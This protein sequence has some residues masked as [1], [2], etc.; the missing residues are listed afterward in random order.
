MGDQAGLKVERAQAKKRFTSNLRKLNSSLQ[1]GADIDKIKKEALDLEECFGKLCDLHSDYEEIT[2]ADDN[3]YLKPIT[4]GFNAGMKSYYSALKQEKEIKAR[5]EGAPLIASVER[6]F[7]DIEAGIEMLNGVD[8][9]NFDVHEVMVDKEGLE[10]R[11]QEMFENIKKASNTVDTKE[12]DDKAG[13]LAVKASTVLRSSEILIRKVKDNSLKQ[14]SSKKSEGINVDIE[15]PAVAG[16]KVIENSNEIIEVSN[17]EAQITE[18]SD[19]VD[20]NSDEITEVSS[21]QAQIVM[22]DKRLQEES[23][24]KLDY[25]LHQTEDDKLD[26][27]Q[28]STKPGKNIETT[29][30]IKHEHQKQIRLSTQQTDEAIHQLKRIDLP[31]FHGDRKQWPEFKA[32]FKH[33]AESSMRSQQALAYELKRHV[34]A[35]ADVLIQSVYS[36][37]PGAYEKMWRKLGEVYDDPGA[38]V[39]AALSSLHNLRRPS[40]DFKSLVGFIN[41]IEAVHA[42]L[43]EL[44][45]IQCVSVRDVDTINNLLP[46]AVKMEWNRSYNELGAVEKL[47]PFSKYM[48]FLEKERA[49]MI[50][51]SEHSPLQ[52]TRRTTMIGTTEQAFQCYVHKAM[53]H[54][55]LNCRMFRRMTTQEK[56]DFCRKEKL[57]FRCLTQHKRDECT[58]GPCSKCGKSHNPIMCPRNPVSE[59]NEAAPAVHDS[60]PEEVNARGYA[61]ASRAAPLAILPIAKVNVKADTKSPALALL[62]SGSDASYVT[63]QFA[64]KAGLKPLRK[65]K[66]SVTTMGNVATSIPTSL[67]KVPLVST[68]GEVTH[69]EAFGIK[70][71][72]G[73]VSR[74]DEQ[75]VSRLFPCHDPKALQRHKAEV[76]ILIGCDNF[77][78]HPKRELAKAGKNLSL[79]AG[80]L[81]LCLQG[82]HES[83]T[84]KTQLSS[85][86]V[87]TIHEEHIVETRAHLLQRSVCLKSKTDQF[88][89]GEELGTAITPKCGSCRCGKC[90][91]PGH[92]YS[93]VEQQELQMIRDGL[94][95][96]EENERWIAA[97]P[98]LRAPTALPNNYTAT[99]AKLSR[100]EKRLAKDPAWAESYKTQLDDMVDRGVAKKLSAEDIENWSGPTFYISHLAVTSP[101]SASTPIRIVFNSSESHNGISLNSCLAKGPD[102]Y[103]NNILGLLLRWRENLVAMVADIRKM[104]HSIYLEELETHCHRYLWR[105]LDVTKEPDVY[106]IQRVNMGDKPASAIAT[107]ALRMTA[108]LQEK[109]YPQAAELITNSSY[110]DDLIDSVGTSEKAVELAKQVDQVLKFGG[111]VIKCWQFSFETSAHDST[112][113]Q[114][115][116]S[117]LKAASER[118]TAVLGV[119]WIPENDSIVF[120]TTVN[121]SQKSH[122]IHNMPNIKKENLVKSMPNDLS[123][124]MVLQQVMA[125][126]DPLGI[127]SPFL[128]KAKILLRETWELKLGWDDPLPDRIRNSWIQFF[129]K[130]YDVDGMVFERA[131]TPQ[132]TIGS[133]WLIIFSDGSNLAYGFAAYIRWK[134]KNGK[135]WCRLIMAKSRIAP[136]HKT[137]TPRMELNGALLSKRARQVIETEMRFN[138]EKVIHLIDSLTVHSMLHKTS[139]RFQI[140]EGSRIGEIQAATQGDMSE[141]AWLPG[142][143]NIADHVTRGLDPED[144]SQDTEWWKGPPMLYTDFEEWDI[145]FS[146]DQKAESEKEMQCMNACVKGQSENIIQF[147]KFGKMRKLRLVIA[148]IFGIAKH[149]SFK[150]GSDSYLE[151]K[152]IDAANDYLIKVAQ[153]ELHLP[154]KG[155]VANKYRSLNP[156]NDKGIIVVGTRMSRHNPMSPEGQLQALL[157]TKHTITKMLMREAHEKG[158]LGRDA[159]LAKF[160]EHFWTPHADKLAKAVKMNCQLC[161]LREAKLMKQCMGQL[162]K[163]R[164]TPG[165]PFAATML[166]LLGPFYTRGEVQKR[167]TG[168]CYF[169]LLT[170]L[171]ARAIHLECIFGYDTSHFLLGLSRFV[172]LRGWP[173]VIYSDPGSQLVGA[174]NELRDAWQAIEN[175]QLIKQ[176]AQYGTRWVFGPADSPWHQGAVEALVKTVKKCLH[177]SIHSQRLT[178]AEYLSVAYETANMVNERPIGFRPTPDSP[179]NILTPNS[180]L[181]GRSTASCPSSVMPS[182]GSLK[183]RLQVV[184]AATDDFWTRWTELYAPSLVK[185]TKWYN[186]QKNLKRGDIVLVAE[187]GL[188]SSY[189]LARVVE[190]KIG[191]DGHVRSAKLAYKNYKVGEPLSEYSGAHDTFITRAIQR[192]ALLVPEEDINNE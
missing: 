133:P 18:T 46:M 60:L 168:K 47:Q 79:M 138:F 117:Q 75:V 140:Y 121:F 78:L 66:L 61:C 151:P 186:P 102:S 67:F 127:I 45:Q 76:D 176:G 95:H 65:L 189:K 152:L 177:F 192:L 162:P 62:D 77:G 116:T 175:D 24:G 125:I 99:K 104:F 115:T 55:T 154:E 163:E 17:N 37:R 188:K 15:M 145:K 6:S 126:Y 191:K 53:G 158:H 144:L 157:P 106:A 81:G 169:I 29:D 159:T 72:T 71:I 111:F 82:A 108:S 165:P 160:R 118:E 110:M 185:Q 14:T 44:E 105:D 190:V 20:E 80:K 5:R 58:E 19:K 139:T 122:G 25:N 178:P 120:H 124:R 109:R 164:L 85:F 167:T 1:L 98:W 31:D 68:E 112:G 59:P 4:D 69:I 161:K 137:T 114:T 150:G 3:E 131:L 86:L 92:T 63:F 123:R 43:E 32:M 41:D 132:S 28:E 10:R 23:I 87:K 94:R 136:L 54:S 142:N 181:L 11:V 91:L 156:K 146:N 182:C 128:L 88:I 8:T 83:L 149:K 70:E 135:Y 96:D 12:L 9:S 184:Q 180:L 16:D 39:S 153:V 36:T 64:N 89:E 40:E 101:K 57:C 42:Q 2:N 21:N 51:T 187:S 134:L 7:R 172:N 103:L 143:S 119:N 90:P 52:R 173:A 147:E 13:A 166:D 56:F 84:E 141:W 74:L 113:S 26:N 35:P 33:L 73:Q 100:L 155:D 22:P 49:A 38:S 129:E 27:T 48:E 174:S 183:T 97:Y 50:R 93:F 107:E 171:A 148:R 170:D 130:L 34:K 30:N 179:I